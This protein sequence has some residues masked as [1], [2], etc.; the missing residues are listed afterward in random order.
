MINNQ[1]IAVLS[2]KVAA[3]EAA[4]KNAGIELPEVTSDDNGKALQVVNGAWATGAIIPT[5]PGVITE[6]AKTAIGEK[7]SVT[8]TEYT[9]GR[10]TFVSGSITP[11]ENTNADYQ[12]VVALNLVHVPVNTCCGANVGTASASDRTPKV[13]TFITDTNNLTIGGAS[14]ANRNFNFSCTYINKETS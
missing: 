6:T 11:S 3:L 2:E 13:Y 9:Y 1:N 5:L 8:Y 10:V 14:T 7:V 12:E 4:I